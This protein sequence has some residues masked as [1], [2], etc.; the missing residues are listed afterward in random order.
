VI[1]LGHEAVHVSMLERSPDQ[2]LAERA[3]ADYSVLVTFDLDFGH[4][5][6]LGVRD[7]PGIRYRDPPVRVA[8]RPRVN[9][10]RRAAA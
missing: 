6:A 4:I 3:E 1:G 7:K 8:G 5:L 2:L 10:A 9:R